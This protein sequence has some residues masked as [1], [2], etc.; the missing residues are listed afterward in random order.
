MVYFTATSRVGMATDLDQ[1]FWE[2]DSLVLEV[3][4]GVSSNLNR[5]NYVKDGAVRGEPFGMGINAAIHCLA[6]GLSE[7]MVKADEA[8]NMSVDVAL[9]KVTDLLRV[10]AHAHQRMKQRQALKLAGNGDFLRTRGAER[11][12]P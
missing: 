3:E 8:G 10:R 7:M 11:I 5:H 2:D 9:K 1:V 12:C 6:E 4:L